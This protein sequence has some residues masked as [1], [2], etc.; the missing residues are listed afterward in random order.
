MPIRIAYVLPRL[1]LSG[2]LSQIRFLQRELPVGQFET[3]VFG[4]SRTAGDTPVSA[5]THPVGRSSAADPFALMRLGRDIR[6]WQPQVVHAWGLDQAGWEL[7][8][9]LRSWARLGMATVH[10]PPA[11]GGSVFSRGARSWLKKCCHV[12]VTSE[13]LQAALPK[14]RTAELIRPLVKEASGDDLAT[15]QLA[16]MDVTAGSRFLVLAGANDRVEELE[17]ALQVMELLVTVHDDLHLVVLGPMA[18]ANWIPRRI[19]QYQLNRNVHLVAASEAWQELISLASIVLVP[20]RTYG[21]STTVLEGLAAGVPVAVAERNPY[22]QLGGDGVVQLFPEG[23][24]GECAR[25][26][27]QLLT[28]EQRARELGLAGQQ[29]FRREINT[30]A[31]VEQYQQLYRQIGRASETATASC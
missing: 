1:E 11:R 12:C 26:L 25:K 15:S 16:A 9:P 27:H 18:S 28:D 8:W 22:R 5:S 3:R 13:N 29:W 6:Q 30:A 24:S 17:L 4:F 20:A 2:N 21:F 19:E 7:Y 10:N 31:A 23:D 14:E